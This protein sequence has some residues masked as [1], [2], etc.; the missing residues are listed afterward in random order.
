MLFARQQQQRW[1]IPAVTP[2]RVAAYQES[3]TNTDEQDYRPG[4]DIQYLRS[5]NKIQIQTILILVTS[6]TGILFPTENGKEHWLTT[7][8]AT[9]HSKTN[10]SD[11]L[12][13]LIPTRLPRGGAFFVANNF[14]MFEANVCTNRYKYKHQIL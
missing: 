11:Y 12:R 7:T 3:P 1:C 5:L 6:G 4:P 13:H 14:C 10:E 8:R 2:G 9:N